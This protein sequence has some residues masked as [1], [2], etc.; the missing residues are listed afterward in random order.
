ML[1]NLRERKRRRVGRDARER[2]GNLMLKNLRSRGKESESKGKEGEF[3]DGAHLTR[4]R[5]REG[6]GKGTCRW[7][8]EGSKGRE[9]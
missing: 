2:E 8:R 4:K 7:R 6:E 3:G 1:E 5:G 9:D